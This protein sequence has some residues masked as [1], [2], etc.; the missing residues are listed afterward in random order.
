[1]KGNRYTLANYGALAPISATNWLFGLT[2]PQPCVL[3]EW[4]QAVNITAP[5]DASNYWSIALNSISGTLATFTTVGITAGAWQLKT[6]PNLAKAIADSA[7]AIYVY[8]TKVGSPGV[9]NAMAPVI[10][11]E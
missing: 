8:A 11:V 3:Q 4:R 9:L 7:V 10:Y 1:M 2:L 5:N 6:V